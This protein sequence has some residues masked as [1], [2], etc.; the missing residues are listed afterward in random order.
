[1]TPIEDTFASLV[2]R[3]VEPKEIDPQARDEMRK[4]FF[5]GA[6]TMTT[7]SGPRLKAAEAELRRFMIDMGVGWDQ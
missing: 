7:L 4:L 3:V 1:M 5:A 2:T 6:V